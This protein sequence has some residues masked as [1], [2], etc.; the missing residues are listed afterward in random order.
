M[1]VR[2]EIEASLTEAFNK[3][4]INNQ[5]RYYARD[6][7]FDEI[8]AKGMYDSSAKKIIINT[9]YLFNVAK[10]DM[11]INLVRTKLIEPT[12]LALHV[13]Y[14]ELDHAMQ[15][16]EIDLYPNRLTSQILYESLLI[17]GEKPNMYDK[18]H[19]YFPAEHRADVRGCIILQQIIKGNSYLERYN[20]YSYMIKD[21]SFKGGKIVSPYRK[22]CEK[23]S[24]IIRNN[25]I[26]NSK[27]ED[28]ITNY[29]KLILGLP[30]SSEVYN[31]C[32]SKQH[33]NYII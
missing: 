13:L 29:D 15:A 27:N 12:I 17:A 5:L 26:Y 2:D 11:S 1:S 14:H 7:Y 8:D 10:N 24:T 21:Y 6:I 32:K 18:Y 31:E 4:V 23:T 9:P 30:I 3:Y 19:D 20:P 28:K 33:I 25:A 16:K 22:Y